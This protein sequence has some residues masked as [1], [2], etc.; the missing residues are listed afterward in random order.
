[1][2]ANMIDITFSGIYQNDIE[3]KD[4]SSEEANGFKLSDF[5][6]TSVEHEAEPFS[7]NLTNPGNNEE[8]ISTYKRKLAVSDLFS[9]LGLVLPTKR[10][11]GIGQH[12]RQ[13]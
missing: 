11:Y 10:L 1:M 13:F 4:K 12:N 7:F 8:V 3:S 5:G 6:F 2:S 9:E